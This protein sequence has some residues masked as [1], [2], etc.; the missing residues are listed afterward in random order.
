[1]TAGGGGV[2]AGPWPEQSQVGI[3]HPMPNF[4][5]PT[6]LDTAPLGSR[7]PSSERGK[8]QV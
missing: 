2:A 3:S 1:M 6:Q 4:S 7:N 5:M 8:T